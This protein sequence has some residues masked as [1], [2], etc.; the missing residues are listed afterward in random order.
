MTVMSGAALPR[1]S[2]SDILSY[3][4]ELDDLTKQ[5]RRPLRSAAHFTLYGSCGSGP[6]LILVRRLRLFGPTAWRRVE[7]VLER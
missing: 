3:A 1:V 2:G 6:V 5:A 7:R 4:Y